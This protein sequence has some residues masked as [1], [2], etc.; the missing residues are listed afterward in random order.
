MGT[1]KKRGPLFLQRTCA[2][3]SDN[4]TQATCHPVSQPLLGCVG[5]SRVVFR[6]LPL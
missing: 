6:A 1:L 3:P 2:R 4:R 5:D